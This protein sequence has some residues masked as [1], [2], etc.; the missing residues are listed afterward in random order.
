MSAATVHQLPPVFDL[1]AVIREEIAAAKDAEPA[2][3]VLDVALVAERVARRIPADQVDSV[4]QLLLR[5]RVS[6]LAWGGQRDAAAP[7][8]TVAPRPGRSKVDAIRADWRAR[9]AG[10]EFEGAFAV[11]TNLLTATRTDLAACAERHAHHVAFLTGVANALDSHRAARVR[12][13]PVEV[14]QRIAEKIPRPAS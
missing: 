3:V 5:S 11:P 12:D 7:A 1:A 10:Y 6:N 4:L 14:Q 13:L 2:G 8:S 9:L